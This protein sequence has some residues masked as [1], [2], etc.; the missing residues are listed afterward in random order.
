MK[1]KTLF[2]K[3]ID[4]ETKLANNEELLVKHSSRLGVVEG[5]LS[6]NTDDISNI[7][8]D[9]NNKMDKDTLLTMS[10]LSQELKLAITGGSVAVVGD[11]SILSNNIVDNQV[12]EYKATFFTDTNNLLR[13]DTIKNNR[14]LTSH[15]TEVQYENYHLSD[16]IKVDS[17][18]NYYLKTNNKGV[19]YHEFI[20]D[21]SIIDKENNVL[22]N[23]GVFTTSENCKYIKIVIM[24]N[25]NNLDKYSINKG[26]NYNV[27]PK[28]I[29]N[30]YLDEEYIKNLNINLD[31][32]DNISPANCKF[33][34]IVHNVLDDYS[35][36]LNKVFNPNTG[37]LVNVDGRY[38]WENIKVN[39][40]TIYRTN[41]SHYVSFYDKNKI[42]IESH[43]V[44]EVRTK[45]CYAIPES[46]YYMNIG[47]FNQSISDA[48]D[49]WLSFSTEEYKGED[50]A[51]I[52]DEYINKNRLNST[53]YYNNK[54]ICVLGDS[55]T[56]Q[57]RWQPYVS[58]YF[59]CT[60]INRGIGGTTVFNDGQKDSNGNEKWM[61]SDYRINS[62]PNDSDVI[63]FWGGTN[64]WSENAEM[65]TLGDGNFDDK[66][67]KNAYAL[68][69]KKII[70]KFPSKKIFCM[71]LIGGRGRYSDQ[72]DTMEMKNTQGLCMND[73]SKAIKEV[74]EYYGIPCIDI[75]GEAGINVF[76]HTR[77]IGDVVHPNDAG[78]KKIANVVI[79]GL[80]RFEP[81]DL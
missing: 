14:T 20:D 65:G 67:F 52:K 53:Y 77:Y 76:N 64:D 48:I 13:Y 58:E 28:K 33:F 5:V 56:A 37:A 21:K 7:K 63:I 59:G 19:Y 42:F 12:N 47:N 6:E 66:K 60:M 57:G 45:G 38:M 54:K 36:I 70:E 11:N 29:K 8:N 68:T 16:F 15:G 3:V 17:S 35:V 81:I 39:N 46:A 51:Y 80:K 26:Y 24:D 69:L 31:N 62:I 72:N 18:S 27:T 44:S 74:A 50:K 9:I 25:K 73:Y 34:E 4:G 71:S 79:N 23:E 61:C 22:I 1:V 2:K 41:F 10:N 40:K 55:I 75:H 43:K 78:A 49:F 30:K 32:I